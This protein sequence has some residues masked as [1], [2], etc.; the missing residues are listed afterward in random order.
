MY[1][2]TPKNQEPTIKS[3]SIRQHVILPVHPVLEALS[4]EEKCELLGVA[5]RA[6]GL[7]IE[8]AVEAP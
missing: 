1:S 4:F 5:L 2:P 3:I 8:L 7:C 6:P